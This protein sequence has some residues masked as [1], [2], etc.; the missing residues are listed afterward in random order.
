MEHPIRLVNTT[1]EILRWRVA[2]IR[3]VD[4]DEEPVALERYFT[5]ET[6]ATQFAEKTQGTL[7]TLDTSS[8]E[9]LDGMTFA[10]RDEAVAAAELGEEA[11]KAKAEAEKAAQP[12][13]RLDELDKVLASLLGV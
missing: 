12:E 2:Y 13:A 6:A 8:V 11:Y 4:S 3:D 1:V 7:E 9:W 10:S 5:D